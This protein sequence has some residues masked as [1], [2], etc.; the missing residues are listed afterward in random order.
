MAA[1]STTFDCIDFAG[2]HKP[3]PTRSADVVAVGVDQVWS[4]PSHALSTVAFMHVPLQAACSPVFSQDHNQV[5]TETAVAS[6]GTAEAQGA[7]KTSADLAASTGEQGVPEAILSNL[8]GGKR[9]E[10]RLNVLA[11]QRSA[12]AAV[13]LETT[14]SLPPLHDLE[15]AMRWEPEDVSGIAREHEVHPLASTST[16]NSMHINPSFEPMPKL[17]AGNNVL[18]DTQFYTPACDYAIED[19]CGTSLD[20]VAVAGGAQLPRVAGSDLRAQRPASGC[21]SNGDSSGNVRLAGEIFAGEW[22]CLL[23]TSPSPRDRTRSR[24]PSSA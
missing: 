19:T 17:K 15:A 23:Y 6:G 11:V 2:S 3:S 14:Q 8:D 12:I 18:D 13:F 9:S 16:Y 5:D 24:M 7:V 22:D 20:A 1:F 4:G 10:A 21:V